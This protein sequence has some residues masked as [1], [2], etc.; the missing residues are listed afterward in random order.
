[1]VLPVI[2]LGIMALFFGII[3]AYASQKLAVEKDPRIEAIEETL[4]AANC[5]ACGYPGCAA[6]A[7]AVLKGEA[8]V[9]G[10]T[11]GG[12]STAN[13]IASILGVNHEQSEEDTY[14]AEVTCLGSKENCK[15]LFEYD[16]IKDCKAAMMY[17]NGFKACP[18]GCLGLGTCERICPFNAITMMDNGLPHID[19][20]KCQGCNRCANECPRQVIRMINANTKHHVRCSSKAPGKE[21]RKVCAVGCIACGVCAK[22]CPVD[23]ITIEENLASIDSHTCINCG[24]CAEKCPQGCITADL[25]YTE[26]NHKNEE[27]S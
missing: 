5:G 1:M 6:F 24:K 8:P 3:L 19:P 11:P 7:E 13:E 25:E 23:A 21:V 12:E 20:E 14:V 15:E 17:A 18:Y 4:P 10:C 9:D 26:E 16:G 27:A 22:V 2:S